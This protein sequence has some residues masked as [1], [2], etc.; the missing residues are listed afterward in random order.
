MKRILRIGM[1][2]H[3]TNCTLSAIEPVLGEDEIIYA[4]IKV[5]PDVDNNV[6][7]I[8]NLK[9]K[10]KDDCDIL[11]GYEAGCLGFSL[12]RKLTKKG[13]RCVILAPTTMLTQQGRRLKTDKRDALMITSVLLIVDTMQYTF[14]QIK[15]MKS[16]YICV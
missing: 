15:M 11:C 16:R 5:T 1:D 4:N 12:Y 9:V 7:F 3:S 8:E 14:H 2:V 6:Q 13:I 10:I